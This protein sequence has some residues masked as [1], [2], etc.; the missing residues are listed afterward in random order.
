MTDDV[1]FALK[2]A[3]DKGT[4]QEVQEIIERH[5]VD[6]LG[7]LIDSE[8]EAKIHDASS[9]TV[10]SLNVFHYALLKNKVQFVKYVLHDREIARAL[11]DG[12][13]HTFQGEK[14]RNLALSIVLAEK[15]TILL[16]V[17]LQKKTFLFSPQDLKS[18]IAVCMKNHSGYQH[19]LRNFLTL[20]PTP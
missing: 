1:R 2:G 7:E 5:H 3:M 8:S 13:E 10:A 19:V 14:F 11:Y 16:K 9:L 20:Y 12:P 18:F 15:N 17:L 6:I 4:D